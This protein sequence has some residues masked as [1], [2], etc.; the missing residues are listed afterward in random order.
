MPVCCVNYKDTDQ[1]VNP[2]SLIRVFAVGSQKLKRYYGKNVKKM[3]HIIFN[4]GQGVPAS[5]C[6]AISKDTDQLVNSHSL[7]RVFAVR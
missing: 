5:V 6:F 4:L 2:R 3:S 7:I 1:L